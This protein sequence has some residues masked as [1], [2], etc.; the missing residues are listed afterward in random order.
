[1]I[2][3]LYCLNLVLYSQYIE[4]IHI[5]ADLRIKRKWEALLDKREQGEGCC[6]LVLSDWSLPTFLSTN[7]RLQF[8][9]T[10]AKVAV[11]TCK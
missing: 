10:S 9:F 7:A 1:M 6:W 3:V 2:W 4:K 8:C 5:R 11:T